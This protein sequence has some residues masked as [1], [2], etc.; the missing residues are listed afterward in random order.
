MDRK[1]RI[2]LLAK[3]LKREGHLTRI[4]RRL[5]RS[6][7][8]LGKAPGKILTD[9]LGNQSRYPTS[10]IRSMARMS[11]PTQGIYSSGVTWAGIKIMDLIRYISDSGTDP[12]DF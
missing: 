12:M 7:Q 5:N 3:Y 1:N 6:A 9:E 8:T 10:G 4:M 2:H 11:N